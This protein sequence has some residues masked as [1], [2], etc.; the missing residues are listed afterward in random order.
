MVLLHLQ[1]GICDMCR[2]SSELPVPCHVALF[3]CSKD[4]AK[5]SQSEELHTYTDLHGFINR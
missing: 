4:K 5:H 1:V 2:C 3:G